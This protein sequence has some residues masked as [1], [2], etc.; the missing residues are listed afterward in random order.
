MALSL[1]TTLEIDGSQICYNGRCIVENENSIPNYADD[2]SFNSFLR[3]TDSFTAPATKSYT[4][5]TTPYYY[6]PSTQVTTK[7]TTSQ[8]TTTQ[9]RTTT[10]WWQTST[11]SPLQRS[12]KYTTVSFSTMC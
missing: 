1:N 6:S 11:K 3:R 7:Y 8:S 9:P 12:T 5:Q 4:A 10:G 2:V